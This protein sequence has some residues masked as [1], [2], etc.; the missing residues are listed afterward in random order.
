MYTSEPKTN[1][2]DFDY[3]DRRK[4]TNYLDMW[5]YSNEIENS[6]GMHTVLLTYT[7]EMNTIWLPYEAEGKYSFSGDSEDGTEEF[8]Y[9]EFVDNRWMANCIQPAH[10]VLPEE[11][12]CYSLEL[13]D[14]CIYEIELL[15][16]EYILYAEKVNRESLIFHNYRVEKNVEIAIGRLDHNDIIYLN[17][18][19]SKSHATI[20]W[21]DPFWKVKDCNSSNGTFVNG[22]QICEGRFEV[23]DTVYIMGLQIILGIGFISINDGNNR[24]YVKASKLRKVFSDYQDVSEMPYTHQHEMKFFNRL[25]RRRQALDVKPISVEAPPLS[26]SSNSIPLLLRMGSPLVMSSTSLLAGNITSMLSSVLFPVLTQKY[27]DKQKKEYEERRTKKYG[28]YLLKKRNEIEDEIIREKKIL[29]NNY[30]ELGEVLLYPDTEEH[31]WERRKTDDDFLTL[32]LGNGQIPLIA[33]C[34]YPNRG[35]EI[36][37]D[38]LMDQMYELVETPPCIQQAPILTSFL[39]ERICGVLGKREI[40]IAFVKSLIMQLTLLHSYDEVKIIVLIQDKELKTLEF[41]KYLPHIWTD[42]K[43][44]R[45]LA[46]NTKEAYQISEYL[47]REIGDSIEKPEDLDKILQKRPYYFV[48][49]FDKRIFDS[50]EMLKDVMQSEKNCGISVLA[51]FD[52]LPKECEK[53]FELQSSGE[54]SVVY[55]K[56]IE[57]ERDRFQMDVFEASE[58]AHSMK[59][60]SNMNLKLAS[61][62]F[63]LPKMISFLEMFRVG[64]VEYLNPLK[65]WR[66]NNP[67]KSLSTP[68]GVD[69]DGNLFTL[70]LH[71]KYQGPHGLVAGM[72]GSGKSEFIITYILSMAVNFHPDE[73]AFILIDYKGGGLAGA[74]EDQNRGIHLPHLVGTI[75][76]LD[77]AAIQRSLMSIQ[78]ELMRRQRIFNEAKSLSNEGTMDIYTYQKLYRDKKVSE[79]LPHLFIISDEFAELKSQEP[80]FMDQ[81]I[82]AARIGRSLGV[83]LILAT[84][85]PAGVVNDQIW[86][87]TKFRV[88]L[89]VQDRGDSL[90]M[91]KRPEAAELKNTG[92]FYL[93]VGYNEFFALGQS[94]WCGAPYCPQDKVIIQKDDEIQFVDSVGQIVTKIRP[95]KEINDSGLKQIVA[96][97]QYLSELAKREGFQPHSLWKEPLK[98]HVGIEDIITAYDIK[99]RE[100]IEIPIGMI[101]DPY[102]QSQ[103]PLEINLQ[104]N[105]NILIVG[106]SSSGKTTFVQTLLYMLTRNYTPEQ[107]N[108][109]ILDFSSRNLSI[110]QKMPHCGTV[111]MDENEGEVDRLMSVLEEMVEQRKKM[112]SDAEVS[113]YDAYV[114]INSLPLIVVVID[115]LAAIDEFKKGRELTERLTNLMRNGTSY[116]IKVVATVTNLNDCSYRMQH[117]F[118]DTYALQANDQYAYSNILNIR[119]KFEPPQFPGRG[120]C[121]IDG[122]GLEFQTALVFDSRDE[123]RRAMVLRERLKEFVEAYRG[124]FKALQIETARNDETFEEFCSHFADDRMPLGYN[125]ESGGKVAIP[126]QQLKSISLYLGNA[127][128]TAFVLK[129]IL[130]SAQHSHM[131]IVVLHRSNRSLFENEDFL[132]AVDPERKFI[133]CLCTVDE[134]DKLNDRII[135]MIESRTPIRKKFC[136]EHGIGNALEEWTEPEAVKKW[137]KHMRRET[138]SVFVLFE[139]VLD[140]ELTMTAEQVGKFKTI[141]TMSKGYNI[142]FCGCSYAEDQQLLDQAKKMKKDENDSEEKKERVIDQE[143]TEESREEM[144]VREIRRAVE[145]WSQCFN[146]DKFTLMFGGRFDCQSLVSLPY[147]YRSITNPCKPSEYHRYL[148]YY[149]EKIVRMQMP[150]GKVEADLEDEDEASII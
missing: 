82:S 70:D 122:E 62:A 150:V 51:V 39:E 133:H 103:Y 69:T 37:E 48:V 66:E 129:N 87:N 120:M 96:V 106:A 64:R 107:V 15:D 3:A 32:R 52:D 125:L 97:V 12:I 20:R 77:G 19:V 44:F 50:M 148:M 141:F 36:D 18:R 63:A 74:F 134:I 109:Y 57:K 47:K 68:V 108:Y 94:A 88:C 7:G 83:H 4:K 73:V 118:S 65:R 34:E 1:S 124:R 45:F 75:T 117:E 132:N 140:F 33:S 8:L 113:S 145:N 104:K 138:Q 59:K 135:A 11:K 80:D 142:Y 43:D 147:E 24:V 101:D 29:N 55:L 79:A 119:C 61:Q 49:A 23:G 112:F 13:T 76:N 137:R 54:H 60:I 17:N 105:R 25:P 81:L 58:A 126:L 22:R 40:E 127:F 53:I 116:G 100:E 21:V 92:R 42:Q 86:S 78:S 128:G 139:S 136:E 46:V 91:L 99:K 16:Q 146:E 38:P 110:F 5:N 95:K 26:L 67:V 85:K 10:F 121:A 93:Q 2:N 143:T 56:Q 130:C 31:L 111:L 123:Q 28:E 98:E 89:K 144:R 72:T 14:R 114:M 30:P 102:C 27:T 131:K 149:H 6:I 115:N 9:F 35:F 41:I 90:E 71:E 84:Q